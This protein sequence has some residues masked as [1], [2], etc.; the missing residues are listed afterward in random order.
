MAT[1][2]KSW[3]IGKVMLSLML[4][5]IEGKRRKGWQRMRW[6][7]SITDP[8]DRN[9]NRLQE[10]VKDRGAWHAAVHGDPLGKNTGVG[11]HAL[12]QGI[13]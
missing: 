9:L 2:V 11:C 5:K 7:D 3:L 6:L 13:F 1:G 8:M 4:G 10:I 12:L